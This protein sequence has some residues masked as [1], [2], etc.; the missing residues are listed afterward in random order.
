MLS[1]ESDQSVHPPGKSKK[2]HSTVTLFIQCKTQFF[3]PKQSQDLDPSCKMDL[4]L[5]DC[6]E[7]RKLKFMA[8]LFSIRHGFS[9]PKQSQDL[10]PSCKMDL[11]LWVVLEREK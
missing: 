4:D 1:E 10:D 6:F 8:E 9:L 3:L 7:K 2:N 5:W 11:D